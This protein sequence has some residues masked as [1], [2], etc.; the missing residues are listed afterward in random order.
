MGVEKDCIYPLKTKEFTEE[1]FF[2]NGS[3]MLE[4]KGLIP[5]IGGEELLC[6][7]IV[8]GDEVGAVKVWK[9]SQS[10]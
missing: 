6:E 9:G 8:A 7:V 2:A 5:S 4:A 1:F 10:K 3:E